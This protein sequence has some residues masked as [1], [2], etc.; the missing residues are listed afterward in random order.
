MKLLSTKILSHEQQQRITSAEITLC[1]YD[2][3]TIVPNSFVIP[4][5]DYDAI[6]TSQNAAQAYL[7]NGGDLKGRD[8]FCVGEK[9]ALLLSQNGQKVIE[10]AP[11]SLEL[12]DKIIKKHKNRHFLYF[13]GNLRRPELPQL[14]TQ[15]RVSFTEQ[16]AYHTHINY[17]EHGRDFDSILF[18]SPSGVSSYFL[19]AQTK[20]PVAVCIGQTTAQAAK[21][22]T[23]NIQ[24]AIHSTV[25]GV[26]DAALK[27]KISI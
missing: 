26:I 13:S 20:N 12:G 24:V 27:T 2:A 1:M 16:I 11:N 25:D 3:L 6:F 5:E 9:A 10:I 15:N 17:F 19:N 22:F 23:T 21:E 8:V 4:K 18:F 7:N 14:L